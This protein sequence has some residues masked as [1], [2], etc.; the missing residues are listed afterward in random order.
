MKFNDSCGDRQRATRNYR[1]EMG[2]NNSLRQ[3]KRNSAAVSFSNLNR[4]R[5]ARQ[6]L[7]PTIIFANFPKEIPMILG[8]SPVRNFENICSHF[9]KKYFM[10]PRMRHE[11]LIQSAMESSDD[12]AFD[13]GSNFG[14]QALGADLVSFEVAKRPQTLK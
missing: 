8:N 7:N 12:G 6:I 11:T 10:W 2:A 13:G 5:L 1:Y 3:S 4:N 9:Q 14:I